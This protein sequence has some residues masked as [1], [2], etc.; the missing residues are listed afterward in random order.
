MLITAAVLLP[1]ACAPAPITAVGIAAATTTGT[2]SPRPLSAPAQVQHTLPAFTR[3]ALAERYRTQRRNAGGTRFGAPDRRLLTLDGDRVIE[4]VGDLATARHVAVIVP[5]ADTDRG[6]FDARGPASPAGAAHAL[7]RSARRLQPDASLAVIGWLGYR[8]PRL[9]STEVLTTERADEGARELRR[10]L[11]E[12]TAALAARPRSAA[13]VPAHVSVLCHSYGSVVCTRA[14]GGPP[15]RA[16]GGAGERGTDVGEMVLFGSPGAVVS[17]VRAL[18]TT[19]R[20]WAGR[21]AGD[22]TSAV[23]GIRFLGVG[24]GPDPTDPEFG[25]RR[26]A[27]GDLGHS[28]YFTPGGTAL[29]NLTRIVLGRHSEV[30]S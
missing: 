10:W 6:T 9:L 16:A 21:A 26:F 1:L 28:G 25:A 2:A 13:P 23:P 18:G 3:T 24:F 7:Y 12:L 29:H 27:A 17:S 19:A 22:W 11:A 30:T 20:I 14:A 15:S 5:G 4:V 8:T